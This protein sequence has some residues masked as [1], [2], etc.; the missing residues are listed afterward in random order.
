MHFFCFVFFL[1]HHPGGSI[2][3]N[4]I[5]FYLYIYLNEFI[6]ISVLITFFLICFH[7]QKKKKT[8]EKQNLLTFAVKLNLLAVF[9]NVFLLFF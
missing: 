1:N 3:R 6:F 2:L 5:C 7:F 9:V 4:L 8:K